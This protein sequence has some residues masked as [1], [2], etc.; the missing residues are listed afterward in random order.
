V[1]VPT[2]PSS[3]TAPPRA[4][5][6]PGRATAGVLLGVAAVAALGSGLAAVVSLDDVSAETR[7]VET[8]RAYGYLLCAGLFVLLARR[9]SGQRGLWALVLADKL[10]LTVTAAGYAA[11]GQAD[12]AGI[13]VVADGTLSVVLLAALIACRGWRRDPVHTPAPA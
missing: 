13:V 10:A 3:A 5:G 2:T 11:T 12:D 6:D 4:P 1:N 9:P 7:I 8:W